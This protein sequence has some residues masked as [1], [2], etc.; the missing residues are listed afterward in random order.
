MLLSKLEMLCKA[1]CQGAH[2]W[3]FISWASSS[4]TKRGI[5]LR[6]SAQSGNN[7]AKVA[8]LR[9]DKKHNLIEAAVSLSLEA[10]VSSR[11]GKNTD[12]ESGDVGAGL[13]GPAV[14][15]RSSS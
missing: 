9:D 3:G 8:S 10:E 5:S 14:W 1:S 11:T 4:R 13:F 7:M 15:L 6:Q 12:A 2:S